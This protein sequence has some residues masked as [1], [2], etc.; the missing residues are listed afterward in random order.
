[1]KFAVL[2]Q[3]PSTCH[4]T[5]DSELCYVATCVVDFLKTGLTDVI[6]FGNL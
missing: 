6:K 4:G 3:T 5:K 2:C 1:M